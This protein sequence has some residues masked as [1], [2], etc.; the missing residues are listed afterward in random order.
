MGKRLA[1]ETAVDADVVVPVPDSGMFAAVGYSSRRLARLSLP[2]GLFAVGQ[3]FEAT[4][5]L[6]PAGRAALRSSCA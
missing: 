1:E 4:P 3:S 2:W 6:S 5:T